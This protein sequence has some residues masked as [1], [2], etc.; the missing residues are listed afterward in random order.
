MHRPHL[1]MTKRPGSRR[2]GSAWECARQRTHAIEP[3]AHEAWL[4]ASP[5]IPPRP[6]RGDA[7]GSPWARTA[8]M[9]LPLATFGLTRPQPA[10]RRRHR[11]E[12]RVRSHR[13]PPGAPD[14]G[15]PPAAP[16]PPPAC[17]PRR[18]GRS[19]LPRPRTHWDRPAVIARQLQRP[20]GETRTPGGRPARVPPW[21]RTSREEFGRPSRPP[22]SPSRCGFLQNPPVCRP[23]FTRVAKTSSDCDTVQLGFN[24]ICLN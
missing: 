1:R 13:R 11:Q 24:P 7:P 20:E 15:L 21:G 4:A 3:R 6:A 16:A 17:P 23:F 10:R 12:A 9:R 18:H 2:L 22:R 14:G 8:S 19:S 5:P